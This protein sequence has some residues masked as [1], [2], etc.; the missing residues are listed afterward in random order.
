MRHTDGMMLETP[1][2]RL[3]IGVASEP[4][5]PT[6]TVYEPMVCIVLKGAKQSLIG[7]RV[8]RYDASHCFLA[9]IEVPAMGCIIDATARTPYVAAS[10]MLDPA[11]VAELIDDVP[12]PSNAVPIEGFGVAPVTIEFL[13]AF[14]QYMALLDNPADIPVLGPLRERELLYRLLQ[15]GHGAMLRQFLRTDSRLAQIRRAIDWIRRHF[16][17][18]LPIETLADLAGMSLSTFH[19]HFKAATA[20]SPLQFQKQLR[21]QAARRLMT[22]RP[23]A[24]RAAYAVGY[25]SA[26]QFSRDYARCFGAP[27]RRDLERMR[28]DVGMM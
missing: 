18:K 20:M 28:V 13:A 22:T 12:T 25:E 3:A 4:A 15:S 23:D 11:K 19:R 6:P 24:A 8:I 27:P 26:S 7:D 1:V 16:D 17:Q 5:M 2:P 14:D 9:G 21:L 10:L